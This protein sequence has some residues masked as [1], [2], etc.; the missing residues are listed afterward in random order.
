MLVL[1]NV[2]PRRIGIYGGLLLLYEAREMYGFGSKWEKGKKSR[3]GGQSRLAAPT[4]GTLIYVG[5]SGLSAS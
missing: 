2:I 3:A 5:R 1:P 4:H